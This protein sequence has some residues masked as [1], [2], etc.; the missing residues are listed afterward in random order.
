MKGFFHTCRHGRPELCRESSDYHYLL[1]GNR[2]F[3]LF[4]RW[5]RLDLELAG[6]KKRSHLHHTEMTRRVPSEDLGEG[7]GHDF[8]HPSHCL[9]SISPRVP[10]P[11]QSPAISVPTAHHDPTAP[12][13]PQSQSPTPG[14]A[15]GSP[16]ARPHA[17]AAA[18]VFFSAR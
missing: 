13:A 7:D 2:Q 17:A 6:S 9:T 16:R 8:I 4:R 3:A 1:H 10:R 14:A 18:T 11:A 12:R 15:R 5:A